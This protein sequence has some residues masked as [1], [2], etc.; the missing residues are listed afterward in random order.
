LI[1]DDRSE[2]QTLAHELLIPVTS[3]FRDVEAFDILS[4]EVIEPLVRSSDSNQ[5]V[6]VWC[7]G[8]S[9]GE[10]AYSIA[11]LFLEACDKHKCWPNLKIFA[12]DVDQINVDT[13]SSGSYP[14][15]I[16]AEVSPE[17]LSRFF[18]KRGNC[19]VV[20]NEL[21]Q[22]I[23][24][25]R[26]NLLTNP[27]FT[28]M[29]LVVCRNALIYFRAQPQANAL[30]R[31]HY[32][33]V[34]KGHLFLGPSESLGELSTDFKVVST[35]YKIWQSIRLAS[36]LL[37]L[38]RSATG[39]LRGPSPVGRVPV[40][41]AVR[42]SKSAIDLG[43]D[44]LLKVFGPPPAVLVNTA[45]E[46]VHVY[47]DA[48]AYLRIRAGQVSLDITRVLLEP[49][50]PIVSAL[51]FKCIRESV[52][53]SSEVIRLPNDKDNESEFVQLSALPA[54]ELDGIHYL[55]L[56]FGSVVPPSIDTQRIAVDISQ[57]TAERIEALEHEL[58]MTRE[59][60]QATIEELETANEELQATNEEMMA[61]N[62]ELQSANEELQSVNEELNTVNAEY[63]EKIDILNRI[64]ADLD[65]FT[66]VVATC[67]LF[68]DENMALVRFSEEAA[69]IFRIR[70]VDLG[71]PLSDLNH[72]L[73]Y[74]DLIQDLYKAQN[75]GIMLE[76]QVMSSEGNRHFA[77]RMLPYSIQLT[78]A[79]GMVLTM[80]EVTEEL[81]ASQ[82]LQ[83]IIDALSVTIAVLDVSG[84]ITHI[85]QA[86]RDFAIK[87]GNPDL[88]Q[89]GPGD[90]YLQACLATAVDDPMA[91]QAAEGI[92]HVLA[93][94]VN[95]FKM[96]YPCHSP[97]KERWFL[98]T[99]NSLS[100]FNLGAVVSHFD[101]T[102]SEL[103]QLD[104]AKP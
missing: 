7:A 58:A 56:V 38:S 68:V 103:P 91:L 50:V 90:N 86:W 17:R 10:E 87:N 22:T 8:V 24:F 44:S 27:P 72:S 30:R 32:A 93:G 51:F 79:R 20:K 4:T 3:F 14:E 63:Q 76:K 54:G 104:L 71:R 15:S 77:V 47:G 82:L 31:L 69:R 73:Q 41:R 75:D 62:E 95:H 21:R 57:D 88:K 59:S 67:T 29:N 12:T 52:Q 97:D 19:Y 101:I 74:P 80:V 89:S 9:T 40:N 5:T 70:D 94:D 42:L 13:A 6:R 100:G 53:V 46:L 34:P 11:M 36:S 49:L 45:Y 81:R 26:H 78:E 96:H 84:T 92:A 43:F 37:D 102:P 60:L 39:H 83:E 48:S 61:S 28:K 1:N 23:V 98:M 18:H 16:E 2:A 99:T 33:I 65:N 55:L 35:R 66:K 64:N 85:N 25:A